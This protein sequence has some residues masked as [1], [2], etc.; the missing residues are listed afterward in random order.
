MCRETRNVNQNTENM[1]RYEIFDVDFAFLMH[2][3]RGGGNNSEDKD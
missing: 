1:Y 3:L 2:Y